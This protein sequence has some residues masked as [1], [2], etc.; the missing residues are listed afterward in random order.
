MAETNVTK[1]KHLSKL[2]RILAVRFSKSELRTLCFDLGIEYETLPGETKQDIARELVVHC[3]RRSQIPQIIEV[4]R[5]LRPDIPWEDAPEEGTG[6]PSDLDAREPARKN[7]PAADKREVRIG[8][9]S[10]V[11]GGE[12]NIAGGDVIK[13][14]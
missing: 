3:G 1:Q 9:I 10:D 4:G 2:R 8:G 13:T 11:S 5:Q 6:T 12:I 7:A 14:N